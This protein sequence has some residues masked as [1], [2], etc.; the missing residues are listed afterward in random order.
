MLTLLEAPTDFI[1]IEDAKDHISVHNN[2]DDTLIVGKI[3]AA[4]AYLDGPNG[5]LGA[6]IASQRWRWQTGAFSDVMRF[7]LGPVMTIES[8]SY[9]NDTGGTTTVAP[10]DYYLFGDSEGPYLRPAVSWPRDVAARD[11]A[12]TVEYT[13]GRLVIPEN[14]KSAAL[15]LIGQLYM[16]REQD[17]DVRIFETSFGFHDLA[18]PYRASVVL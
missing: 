12:V 6:A 13:A 11:D 9:R 2:R 10:A 17:V 4:I 5:Y 7:P 15:I 14:L 18:R 1:S 8:V 16:H 3:K